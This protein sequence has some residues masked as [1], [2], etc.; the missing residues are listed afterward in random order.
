[1]KRLLPTLLLGIGL[2][3]IAAPVHA[4]T[5]VAGKVVYTKLGCDYYVVSDTS[6]YDLLEWYG[7]RIPVDGDVLVGDIHSYGF[8][9]LYAI[10]TLG[11]VQSSRAWIEDYF[12]TADSVAQKFIDKCDPTPITSYV[13]TYSSYTSPISYGTQSYTAST[14]TLSYP[15]YPSYSTSVL[16]NNNYYVNSVGNTVHS[17]AYSV[18][19]PSSASARCGDG[20]YSFSQSRSGTCSHHG[21]VSTWY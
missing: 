12:L 4:A 17:P 10:P 9:D 18:S 2:I 6:G 1:M 15:T 5:A 14:P 7:G 13:P 11:N 19:I 21:G 16:S 3:G 8:K 20:T